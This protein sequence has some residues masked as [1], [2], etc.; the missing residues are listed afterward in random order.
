MKPKTPKEKKRH[1]VWHKI[2]KITMFSEVLICFQEVRDTEQF[3]TVVKTYTLNEE[4]VKDAVEIYE[5]NKDANGFVGGFSEGRL[6]VVIFTTA[7]K[8]TV[9]HEALHLAESMCEYRRIP[10]TKDTEE[11]RAM[12]VGEIVKQAEQLLFSTPAKHT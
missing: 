12:M 9:A 4:E 8:G 10:I 3:K 11:L 7:S 1:K 5:R 2:I 6:F